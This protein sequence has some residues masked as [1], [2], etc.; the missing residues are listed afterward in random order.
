MKLKFFL[1][2]LFLLTFF[3]IRPLKTYAEEFTTSYNVVYQVEA[4]G[5]TEVTQRINLKNLTSQYY[6]SN[7]T[8]TIGSTTL[9]DVSATSDAGAMEVKTESKDGK[10]SVNVKFNQQ[11]A[12]EGKLQSF[13]LR[14]KSKDFT[15]SLG[16]TWEVNLPRV[17]DAKNIENYDLVLSVPSSFGNPT[18]I[19]PVPRSESQTFDRLFFTFNKAQ[20]TASGVSVNFGINQIFD[21]NIKYSLN[22]DT[23]FPVLTSVTLPPDTDYQDVLIGMI[24]PKPLNV[25]ADDMGNYLAWYKLPRRSKQEVVINGS[26]KLYI[27]PKT[28]GIP[29][30]SPQE[31]QA[32]TKADRYWEKG[33]PAIIAALAEIFKEGEPKTNKEKSRLIYRYVVSALKYDKSRI[34]NDDIERLGAVTALNNPNSAVCMEF[35]D[36]FITLARAANIPARE[37]D[38]FAYST[39]KDLRPLSLTRDLL[40]AWPEYFDETRGWIMIDPTWENTSGGVDY[41]NKFDLNHLVLA[42]KGS[43]SETPWV[44]DDVEVKISAGDF[45][46]NPKLKIDLDVPEIIWAGFPSGLE[47]KISN[48]GNSLQ[49]SG[50]FSLRTDKVRV[51]GPKTIKTGGI[52]P[53]GSLS[54]KFNLRTPFAWQSYEDNFE[55]EAGGQKFTKKV[56]VRPLFLFYSLPIIF[57]GVIVLILG[58]YGIILGLHIYRE[59]AATSKHK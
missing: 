45:L 5:T 4:D 46:E 37:L 44:S 7:F 1:G 50:A 19:S 49:P 41:F 10:T 16:K 23:L 18:S 32:L 15:Q 43:S 30:F 51:L 47:I 56:T 57:W 58:V 14:F 33:N 17:P 59:K 6:A 35:T 39:N 27:N 21:F 11:V 52:P 26:A 2:L 54:Y 3:L 24:N 28:K 38:G 48:E 22:N 36:L 31:L 29:V 34:N 25:T 9:T 8:L 55:V 12:G 42:I 20:L 40:H 53:F 13:T